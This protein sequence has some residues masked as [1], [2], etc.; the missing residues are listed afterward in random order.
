MSA[1]IVNLNKFRK[2]KERAE[3]ERQADENR[4]KYGRSKIERHRDEQDD[5]RRNKL[6]DSAQL[7]PSHTPSNDTGRESAADND[8]DPGTVS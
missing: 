1:E 4:A 2:A 3:Q 5:A 8:L 6:L 7:V